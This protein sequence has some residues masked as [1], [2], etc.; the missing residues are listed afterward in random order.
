VEPGEFKVVAPDPARKGLLGHLRIHRS[1]LQG[2]TDQAPAPADPLPRENTNDADA[3]IAKGDI[4]MIKDQPDEAI[5]AFDRA[6]NLHQ[7]SQGEPIAIMTRR[8]NAFTRQLG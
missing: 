6:L 5:D 8:R 7:E 1:V 4:H 3:W 2:R